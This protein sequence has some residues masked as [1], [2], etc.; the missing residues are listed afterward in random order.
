MI[1]TSKTLQYNPG[2]PVRLVLFGD[3]HIGSAYAAKNHFK[4][5]LK[6]NMDHNNAYLIGMGDHIDA[7][8]PADI[9]RFQASTI[10]PTYLADNPDEMLMNQANDFCSMLEQYK[11]R[12]LLLV[13]GNH[14]ESIRKRY[15][16]SIHRMICNNLGT[17]NGGR[18][19]MMLLKLTDPVN[20]RTRSMVIMGHHGWG[21]GCNT[22]GGSISK[23][24]RLISGY[25]ADLY[26][27]AHDHDYWVKKI[28]RISLNNS[29]KIQHKNQVLCN[30]GA[31][32][33]TLS[34]NENCSWSESKG[35]PPRVLGGIVLDLKPESKGW[36]DIKV[37]E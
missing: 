36:I 2:E 35:F 32:M 3:T 25:E 6:D 14:C 34:D 16:F 10:D 20:R 18:S 19:F 22:Q 11:D 21:G 33:R 17:L 26:I 30:T 24:A 13:E 8:V 5:F 28:A 27:T 29:G 23:Y 37:I 4:R 31:F 7:I 9:K 1:C 15:G 12:L